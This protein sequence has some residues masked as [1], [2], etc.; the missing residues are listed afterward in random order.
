MWLKHI[1]LF[2]AGL[3]WF[4]ATGVAADASLGAAKN[5]PQWRGP[6]A[7]GVSQASNLPEK[8]SATEHIKWK[9]ELPGVALRLGRSRLHYGFDC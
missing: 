3:I 5:W 1:L 7:Q 8:W 9:V 4:A 2:A 6:N